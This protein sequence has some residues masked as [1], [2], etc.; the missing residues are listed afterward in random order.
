MHVLSALPRTAG[1]ACAPGELGGACSTSAMLCSPAAAAKRSGASSGSRGT[2]HGVVT[3]RGAS[4][5]S[6]PSSLAPQPHSSSH[7]VTR[8]VCAAPALTYAC[9]RGFHA[10]AG[11]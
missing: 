7:V 8:S 3:S 1:A 2:L 10:S 6:W 4:S 5:A 11:H 9:G